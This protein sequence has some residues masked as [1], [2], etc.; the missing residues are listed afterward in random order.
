MFLLPKQLLFPLEKPRWP[1]N[2]IQLEA[3]RLTDRPDRPS[4]Q[5]VQTDRPGIDRSMC[6]LLSFNHKDDSK[7]VEEEPQLLNQSV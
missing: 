2:Y 1:A 5:T 6:V 7:V 3:I 4:R